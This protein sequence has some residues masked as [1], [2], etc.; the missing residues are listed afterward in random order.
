M[1]F[2]DETARKVSAKLIGRV[3][4]EREARALLAKL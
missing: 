3:R 4:T 1:S 2:D